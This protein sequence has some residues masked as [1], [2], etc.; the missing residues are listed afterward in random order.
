MRV[1]TLRLAGFCFGLFGGLF[2]SI[3][4]MRSIPGKYSVRHEISVR[5]RVKLVSVKQAKQLGISIH[6]SQ[7][8]MNLAGYL[9][10]APKLRRHEN[11]IVRWLAGFTDAWHERLNAFGVF[12]NA[13]KDHFYG[14]ASIEFPCLRPNADAELENG[15]WCHGCRMNFEHYK[16]TRKLDNYTQPLVSG[17]D[18]LTELFWMAYQARSRAE[19]L[20]HI[21]DCK[22][23]KYLLRQMENGRPFI[24]NQDGRPTAVQYF[25]R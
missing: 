9:K 23:A 2:E 4:I 22:K 19:F 11:Y 7:E 14:M 16:S 3:P 1:T 24:L 6:E 20:E 21:E 12:I 13:P 15:L 25:C 8:T 10:M 5:K 18:P 17:H